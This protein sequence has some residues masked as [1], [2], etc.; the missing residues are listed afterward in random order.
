MQQRY[1]FA[2]HDAIGQVSCDLLRTRSWRALHE[3]ESA[4]AEE[5]AWS[6]GLIHHRADGRPVISANYWHLHGDPHNQDSLVT[7]LH[8]D[9][10]PSG[11]PAGQLADIIA[12]LAQE[13]SEP[14][15]AIGNYVAGAQRDL[16]PAWPN[17]QRAGEALAKAA[18][19]LARATAVLGRMRAIGHSLSD[20]RL[21]RL[22]EKLT[23]NFVRSEGA[24]KQSAAIQARSASLL[25]QDGVQRRRV[26]SD[27]RTVVML[28]NIH[29]FVRLLE[30]DDGRVLSGE[31]EIM[32][33]RLLAE[34]AEKL[35]ELQTEMSG[36]R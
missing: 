17:R 20:P 28:D 15:T 2:P 26:C 19:Q 11:K 24:A 16:Q 10:V 14:L 22:H 21:T 30:T 33:R 35:S 9:I 29:R 4:L 27:Q 1:G 8:C 36:A 32:V 34:E 3:I 31:T 7:E 12:A 13:M 25:E 23:A 5:S 6:G 18:A